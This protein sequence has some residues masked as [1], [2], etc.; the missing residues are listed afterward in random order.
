M[1]KKWLR[2]LFR[3]RFFVILTL[4][5]QLL[6]F[7]Y[8]IISTT[9]ISD[10]F[11]W[12]FVG[13]SLFVALGIVSKRVKPAFKLTWIYIILTLPVFGGLYYLFWE[14][15]KTGGPAV[16]KLRKAENFAHGFLKGESSLDTETAAKLAPG[17]ER[18]IR[19]LNDFAGFPA[20]RDTSV[21]YLP[22][23]ERKLRV[24]L[25]ELE[26][27]EKYIFLEYFIIEEGVMWDAV[28]D[29]LKRKAREGVTV[30]VLYDDMGCFLKLPSDY[31]RILGEYGIEA[32]VF[33]PFKPMFSVEQNNRDH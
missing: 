10:A 29:V 7:S 22:M 1:K 13:I 4:L 17:Y 3:R 30:R 16:K 8:I 33:N 5:V 19:Y 31:P 18:Q 23:G 24:L 14:M 11:S 9:R 12:L 26:K 25:D 2:S 20:Y 21:E 32:A 15:Q 6:F 27:A 28:L